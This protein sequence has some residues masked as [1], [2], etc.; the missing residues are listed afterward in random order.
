MTKAEERKAIAQALANATAARKQVEALLKV[1]LVQ[2][3]AV[4][5]KGKAA[6]L[7]VGTRLVPCNHVECRKHHYI[8]VTRDGR[9]YVL[10]PKLLKAVK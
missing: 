5:Q 9:A 4:A 10:A 2:L 6:K 1:D 7:R 3:I 8:K